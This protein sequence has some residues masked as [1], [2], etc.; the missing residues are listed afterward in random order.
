MTDPVIDPA[1]GAPDDSDALLDDAS[2]LAAKGRVPSHVV[3]RD[4]VEETVILNLLTGTYHGLNRT[5][6]AM[7]AALEQADSVEQAIDD[8]SRS[9]NWDREIV[10]RDMLG[11]CRDLAT[12]GLIEIRLA[13]A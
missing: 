5:A 12:S 9:K 8:L 13:Q 6:G 7:L 4:F 10:S 3:Y 11:L 2:L 1:P